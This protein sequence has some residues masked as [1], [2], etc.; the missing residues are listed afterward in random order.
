M[1]QARIAD[2]PTGHRA[3]YSLAGVAP[4]AGGIRSLP[5]RPHTSS[6]APIT[7]PPALAS[8]SR[9]MLQRDGLRRAAGARCH[10]T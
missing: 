6:S 3:A 5:P 10:I 9:A 8:A 4:S 1:P 7:M 2:V